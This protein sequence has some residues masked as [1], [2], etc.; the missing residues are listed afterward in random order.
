VALASAATWP[1]RAGFFA[2]GVAWIALV[3]MAVCAIRAGERSRHMWLMLAVAAV[4]SAALWLRLAS[5]LAVRWDLPF[6]TV[7]ALAA[8]AS[9]MLPLAAISLLAR[10]RGVTTG[11]RRDWGGEER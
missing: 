10:R 3:L 7:Y 9:W 5:W 1:A 2:Q 8:W 11:I 4:A 6:E